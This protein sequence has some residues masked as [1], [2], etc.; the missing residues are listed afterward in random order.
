MRDRFNEHSVVSR[1]AEQVVTNWIIVH[2]VVCSYL[3]DENIS[4]ISESIFHKESYPRMEDA[5]CTPQSLMEEGQLLEELRYPKGKSRK[6]HV[7]L[8]VAM[9]S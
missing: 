6:I 2:S 3:E 5:I 9:V 8:N 4:P 1:I 7:L